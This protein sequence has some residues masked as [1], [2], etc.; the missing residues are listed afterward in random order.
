[1]PPVHIVQGK[2][3]WVHGVV[4]GTIPIYMRN[5]K[6]SPEKV[7][8]ILNIKLPTLRNWVAGGFVG[9]PKQL[10][11]ACSFDFWE[12]LNIKVFKELR[13]FGLRR[14]LVGRVVMG[15]RLTHG[16]DVVINWQEQVHSLRKMLQGNLS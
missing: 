1:M 2:V 13:A 8:S 16:A 12:V 6:F 15:E 11:K 9:K 5:Y 3:I 10:T 7:C 14:E 4:T